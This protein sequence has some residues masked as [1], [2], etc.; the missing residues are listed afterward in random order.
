MTWARLHVRLR[1]S[2]ALRTDVEALQFVHERLRE[3]QVLADDVLRGHA[4]QVRCRWRRWPL[5][6]ATT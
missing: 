1:S 5:W 3:L 2:N 6:F 4:E